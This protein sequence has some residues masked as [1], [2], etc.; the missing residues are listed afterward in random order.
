MP[1]LTELL[2]LSEF[3]TQK[4]L[5]DVEKFADHL[6]GKLGV[7]V[8]FTKHFIERLNDERN[9]KEISSAELIRLFKKEYEKH[10]KNVVQMDGEA[11]AVFKDLMTHVNL[12]FVIKDKAGEKTI[13][14]KTVM[15]K[16]DFKTDTPFLDVK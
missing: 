6:W 2:K 7:D 16:Q 15:R 14:A 1:I 4:Q 13:I 8:K 12:P 9:G 11:E 5:N 3:V 10:G